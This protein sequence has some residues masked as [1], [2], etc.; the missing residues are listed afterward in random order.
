MSLW[1]LMGFLFSALLGV[2]VSAKWV[3]RHL[4]GEGFGPVWKASLFGVPLPL[5]SCSVI[6]TGLGLLK[7][8]ASKAAT[9]S[10]ITSTPQTGVES[11]ILAG[12]ILGWP[13]ALVK[14]LFAF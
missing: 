3:K 11:F 14:A 1:L 7:Q 5:C 12:G 4:A 2:L 6:P 13:F 8:G 9:M 10:F